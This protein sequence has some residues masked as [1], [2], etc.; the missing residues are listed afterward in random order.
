MIL[1]S[2]SLS[3]MLFPLSISIMQDCSQA[4]NTYSTRSTRV[5][6]CLLRTRFYEC[7]WVV[8]FFS[9]L[10]SFFT[11]YWGCMCPTD[12]FNLGERVGVFINLL[13]ILN[14]SEKPIFPIIVIYS[15]AVCPKGMYHRILPVVTF[16]YEGDMNENIFMC[17]SSRLNFNYEQITT[18]SGCQPRNAD[19]SES[20][21]SHT[22]VW[23]VLTS[24]LSPI[25]QKRIGT[26]RMVWHTRNIYIYI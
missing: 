15:M 9:P 18:C 10:S 5:S 24:R 21:L 11:I 17:N 16:L 25:C 6:K 26:S 23:S 19:S 14:K 20:P 4:L 13:V 12:P 8:V 1:S 7:V 22:A 2:Y 3:S